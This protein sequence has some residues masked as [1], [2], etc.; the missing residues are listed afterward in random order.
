MRRNHPEWA[1]I[2]RARSTVLM[3]PD[4]DDWVTRIGVDDVLAVLDAQ[5]ADDVRPP[6]PR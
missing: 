5:Y 3:V 4:M 1:P 2:D 6:S